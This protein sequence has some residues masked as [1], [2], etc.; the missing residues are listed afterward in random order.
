MKYTLEVGGVLER[1]SGKI[2]G[3]PSF[4]VPLKS[5]FG[6]NNSLGTKRSWGEVIRM[7]QKVY[8]WKLNEV[9]KLL[10][11]LELKKI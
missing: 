5:E 4:I 11:K 2:L 6:S 7:D 8:V 10:L 9:F 1:N 3:Y